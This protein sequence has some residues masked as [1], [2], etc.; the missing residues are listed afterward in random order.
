MTN[1]PLSINSKLSMFQAV[2]QFASN[3]TDER[4]LAKNLGSGS[5]SGKFRATYG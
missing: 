1:F 5:R 3:Q 2:G 4:T